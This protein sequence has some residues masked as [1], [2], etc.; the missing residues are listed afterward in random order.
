MKN[1]KW[2]G[3]P[4][5][6]EFGYCRVKE[7]K[8]KVLWWYN[9]EC[10]EFPSTGTSVV[11]AIKV[12][13]KDG[14]EFCIGNHFGIG[15]HKLINGGWPGFYH[16]SLDVNDFEK[17]PEPAYNLKEF[18]LEWFESYEAGRRRWQKEN[19]PE[20]FEKSERLRRMITNP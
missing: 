20:E 1:Y 6:T 16:F 10:N 15:H 3:N 14:Y 19:F 8:E 18:Y 7:N 5:K 17:S 2:Q 9:Y 13:M 12:T 4:I 11:P